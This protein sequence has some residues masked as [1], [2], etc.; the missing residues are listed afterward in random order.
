MPNKGKHNRPKKSRG[1]AE[2]KAQAAPAG[3]ARDGAAAAAQSQS[4]PASATPVAQTASMK[5]A[6]PKKAPPSPAKSAAP[7]A[8]AASKGKPEGK[9][10]EAP[11]QVPKEP[12]KPA[13]EKAAVSAT[14]A[15]GV[16]SAEAKKHAADPFDALAGTLPPAEPPAPKAPKFTGPEV[17]EKT[18]TSEKGVR[19]G[20][21]ED[22]LPPEYRLK[23]ET[24]KGTPAPKKEEKPEKPID[25][26]AALDA[27]SGDFVSPAAAP[28]V[29]AP[30]V[31]PPQPPL[32]KAK[33]D[34]A[35]LDALAGDFVSPVAAASVQAPVV[36]PPQP[37]LQ[38][39]DG[40][41]AAGADRSPAPPADKKAK[42]E[43][44]GAGVASSPKPPADKKPKTEEEPSMSL[45]ALSA[46]GDTLAAPEPTPEPPRPL[47]KDIVT[48][49]IKAEKGVRV[50]EREDT[51]P[52]EYRLKEETGKGTPAPKKEE[53]PEKPIDEAAALDALSGDFVS[54]AAAPSVQAPVVKPPQPP[55]QKAKE[56]TAALDALAG[57]FVSPVA[58]AS[59]QAPVVKPPQPPL[60]KSDGKPAAG[61]DRSPAPP[62]D[63]KAKAEQ[64]GAGVASSPK[65][66]ADKKPKTEEE[67]S[68]SL[69][70]LSALGDT[71]AAPEPTPE[72]P[73]PLPKDIVTEKIKA[74]KGVRVG[75]REDTLPP[76]YR[77]KEETGKGTPA[78]KKEEKP[79]KPIDEAAALDALS[80]DFVSPAAAPS[81]QAPVVKPPQ[82][83]LQ[84][85][86]D[87]TAALDALAG[88]FVCPAAA[89]SVQA[90][91]GTPPPA[92]R[93]MS[94]GTTQ[95]LDALSDTLL[96]DTPAPEPQPVPP[97]QVVK[98][99]T[100]V[101]ENVAKLGER[102]DTLPPE[103]RLA[104]Q[105][106]KSA[107]ASGAG[108]KP[109]EK[110]MG[111]TAAI[112]AL[113]GD[114]VP[115]A[116]AGKPAV[117]PRD[118][119]AAPPAGQTAASAAPVVQS[120][121]APSAPK[122][123]TKEDKAGKPE[124]K[125]KK[126]EDAAD[127]ANVGVKGQPAAPKP[128]PPAAPADKA[129]QPAQAKGKPT[130]STDAKKTSKS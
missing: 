46:L 30:V 107:G 8:A 49:K 126:P 33:E 99:K 22:T 77:L 71:L 9:P 121:A 4:K 120:A 10:K 45:D 12:P 122:P 79:E 73:R 74:E 70:A 32:Q 101:E 113:A 7:A 61:A 118:Q 24:G 59:V 57:D 95:A 37:P 53:K 68:M 86:L 26:A 123:G 105:E 93:Q 109:K 50:G 76:E 119:P 43:Q 6:D 1:Q 67:P 38:K 84:S 81:V 17:Q 63:K 114:F 98:E 66:P 40:K 124:E 96:A 106:G 25:E 3:S 27:L 125:P 111:D 55:L 36:K 35:A 15:A 72:P 21:R 19:V 115:S 83:P 97:G 13:V 129:A 104:A 11:Q 39:S 54:P 78:P 128:Q 60:Q 28:S 18:V 92:S 117:T 94:S 127:A 2:K 48:E 42:A 87:D 51:L 102:D 88:D 90:A 65:P 20:E 23:E 108:E 58:A 69:D 44:K 85:P 47:P 110:P 5:P 91:A 112:D 89:P 29:Q 64:K 116:D 52:P 16:G 62:A 31:K 80:G 130:A 56:D 103:Y 14:C 41:P 82:P 100:I 34:T 75:E